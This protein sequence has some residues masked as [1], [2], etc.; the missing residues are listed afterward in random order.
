VFIFTPF[1]LA[2]IPQIQAI[3]TPKPEPILEF[4][5]N[6][7]ESDL[8]NIRFETDNKFRIR[9]AIIKNDRLKFNFSLGDNLRDE[10]D[11]VDISS[12]SY[13]L[14][15]VEEKLTLTF[16][17]IGNEISSNNP[18]LNRPN[19]DFTSRFSR[20]NPLYRLVENGGITLDYKVGKQLSL[21]TAYYAGE[22]GEQNPFNNFFQ[23]DSSWITQMKLK[24]NEQIYLGLVYIYTNNNTNLRTRTG[25]QRYS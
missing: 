22:L 7:S 16:S 23:G 20:K 10:T 13:R 17:L 6:L 3:Q 24:P 4:N 19:T 9:T 14:N 12:L 8:E 11:K 21:T 5:H 15:L 1:I 18:L 2:Q 25:S